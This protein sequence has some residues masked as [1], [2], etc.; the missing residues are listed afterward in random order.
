MAQFD[1]MNEV[2]SKWEGNLAT[3]SSPNEDAQILAQLRAACGK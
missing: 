3:E 1:D 2:L